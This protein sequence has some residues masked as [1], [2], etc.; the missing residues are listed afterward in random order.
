MAKYLVVANQTVTNPQLLSELKHVCEEDRDAQ[1]VLV[2]PATPVRHLLR[3]DTE[4]RAETVARKHAERGRARLADAGLTL[5]DVRV[6]SGDPVEA[7]EEALH[8]GEYAR[9]LISTLPGE[10]SRWLKL[11]LPGTVQSRFGVP[12]THVEA[13]PSFGGP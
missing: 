13:P 10:S 4:D 7:V 11:G 8:D 3:R 2:V 1:F 12:V 9:V 6:G 5:A